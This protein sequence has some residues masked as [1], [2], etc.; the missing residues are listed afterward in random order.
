MFISFA[1]FAF[2]KGFA[3]S[4][5]YGPWLCIFKVLSYLLKLITVIYLAQGLSKLLKV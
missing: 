2:Q 3:S 4:K 5:C 1:I